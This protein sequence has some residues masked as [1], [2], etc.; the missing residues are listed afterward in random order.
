MDLAVAVYNATTRFPTEERFGLSQQVRR[1]AVSIP[2]NI[3]E[4]HSRRSTPDFRRFLNIAYGSRAEVETQILLAQRL[5]YLTES[6]RDDLT[7][8]AEE[9]GRLIN[10]LD[11]SLAEKLD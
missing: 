7:R 2:S 9:I 10:G 5:G 1:A 6:Q 3:A 8:L 11:K 4:G